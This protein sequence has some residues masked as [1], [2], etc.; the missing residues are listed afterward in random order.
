MLAWRKATRLSTL[1]LVLHALVTRGSTMPTA[2]VMPT[3]TTT[4]TAATSA[5][6]AAAASSAVGTT[7]RT[8]A[9]SGLW[10]VTIK[11]GFRFVRKVAAA[12]NSDGRSRSLGCCFASTHFGALLFE[13][14][15]AREPNA[16]AFDGQHFH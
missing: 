5:S 6:G 14:G 8:I 16:V 4:S 3:A 2:P 13:N 1:V 7:I 9:G 12:L 11:I 15:F 10:G